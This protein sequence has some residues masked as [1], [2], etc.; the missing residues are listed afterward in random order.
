MVG[1][2]IART[3][4]GGVVVTGAELRVTDGVG[5]GSAEVVGAVTIWLMTSGG[6]CA[7]VIG[8][9]GMVSV[10]TGGSAGGGANG[11]GSADDTAVVV[12]AGVVAVT[13][14]GL[15]GVSRCCSPPNLSISAPISRASTTA[16][17]SSPRVRRTRTSALWPVS[18]P[19]SRAP[20]SAPN[21]EDGNG[22][23]S[24]VSVTPAEPPDPGTALGAPRLVQ[25]YPPPTYC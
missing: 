17:S 18:A 8:V 9:V 4:A 7:V 15:T 5:G 20:A 11:L 14:A 19:P 3:L 12:G 21:G 25:P 10:L 2:A 24:G 22:A 23:E 16:P 13:T 6:A 1:G